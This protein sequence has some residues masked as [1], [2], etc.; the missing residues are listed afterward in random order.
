MKKIKHSFSRIFGTLLIF[1]WLL[2]GCAKYLLQPDKIIVPKNIKKIAVLEFKDDRTEK[3][4]KKYQNPSIIIQEKL[5][6][7]L[8]KTGKFQIIE[9][10]NIDK[11]ISEQKFQATGITDVM[12]A[13]QIGKLANVDAMIF[14]SISQ[15]GRTIYPRAKLN[16]TVKIV[17]VQTGIIKSSVELR[18]TKN[19]WIYPIELLSD[20]IDNGI[21]KLIGKISEEE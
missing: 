8:S 12:T 21:D 17:E 19:N 11:I 6:A 15:Y 18:A 14:G 1:G 16:I 7:G 4:K 20:V 5:T 10:E 2:P 13:V 9:R 3:E